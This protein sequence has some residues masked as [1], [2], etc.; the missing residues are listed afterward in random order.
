[1]VVECTWSPPTSNE[2]SHWMYCVTNNPMNWTQANQVS[3]K[4]LSVY[5]NS[6]GGSNK[7]YA[8]ENLKK[9]CIIFL[10]FSFVQK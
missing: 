1:M 8:H 10:Y 6:K 4:R 3:W 9:C 2:N 5:T 7:T